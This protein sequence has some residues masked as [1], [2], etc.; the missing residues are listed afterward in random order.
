MPGLFF[1]TYLA[2]FVLVYGQRRPF[3][4]FLFI[5]SLPFPLLLPTMSA[6]LSKKGHGALTD[7]ASIRR[8]MHELCGSVLSCTATTTT[9]LFLEKEKSTKG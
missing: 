5:L 6:I 3:A 2:V 9:V 4:F 7:E 1:G 8:D